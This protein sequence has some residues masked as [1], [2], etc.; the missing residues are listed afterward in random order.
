MLSSCV[1]RYFLED[2]TETQSLLVFDA[3]ITDDK[4]VQEITVSRTTSPEKPEFV[5]ANDVEV[6]VIDEEGNPFRFSPSRVPGH[7]S[8]TIPFEFFHKGAAFKISAMAP[9]GIVESAYEPYLPSPPVDT[10]YYEITSRPT[11]NMDEEELGIQFYLDFYA[12]DDYGSFYRFDVIETYEYHSQFEIDAY[13]NYGYHFTPNDSSLYFCYKTWAID[14]IFTLSTKGFSKNAYIKYHLHFINNR[15]QRL[16]HQYSLLL[17]QYSLTESAYYYWERL[18]QNNQESGSMFAKQPAQVVGNLYYTSNSD[19]K[20][21]GY[22]GVSSIQ[23]KR[24]IITGGVEGLNFDM[25]FQC[26]P[27][28]VEMPLGRTNPNSWPIYLVDRKGLSIAPKWCFDCTLHGGVLQ[29]PDFFN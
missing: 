1:H 5:P 18:K 28:P 27:T 15:T 26:F 3:L 13:Y 12:P 24:I 25:S 4:T 6:V 16:K 11:N 20:I 21:L 8:G 14:K 7:Y 10:I 17:K 9:E 23:K 29:K 2:H 19:D 22:F